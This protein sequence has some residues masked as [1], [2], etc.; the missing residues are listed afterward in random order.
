MPGS[1][2]L[3]G[4]VVG[5]FLLLVLREARLDGGAE[6][7]QGRLFRGFCNGERYNVQFGGCQ[8][9]LLGCGEVDKRLIDAVLDELCRRHGG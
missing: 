4:L 8:N 2:V 5:G 1:V 6:F 3:R 9:G 7:V